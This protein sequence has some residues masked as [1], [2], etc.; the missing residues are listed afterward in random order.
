[1]GLYNSVGWENNL[2]RN[3]LSVRCVQ[4]SGS[5]TA[6]SSSSSGAGSS[7]SVAPCDISNYNIVEIGSQVWMAENLNCEA[8][9]SKC[10]NND[11]N[12][13]AIYG[14]LYSY[15]TAMT[16]CPSGWHLPNNADWTALM[17][18]INPDCR[19]TYTCEGVGIEL[20]STSG[21]DDGN[22]GNSGNG[23]DTYG[24]AALPGGQ[25]NSEVNG[26]FNFIGRQTTFWGATE[27]NLPELNISATYSCSI[28]RNDGDVYFTHNSRATD[29]L[30]VRCIKD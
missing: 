11:P 25:G 17:K 3:L 15:A 5:S 24:F 22:D 6:T 2:K 27:F 16:I 14:R 20:K 28:S 10:Y 30:S 7:S 12:N 13:C 23:Y 19:E 1:M 26:S 8:T 18:H 9:G 29:L 21:W 4:N